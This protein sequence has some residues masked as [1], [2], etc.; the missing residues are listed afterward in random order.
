MTVN[1]CGKAFQAKAPSGR[2]AERGFHSPLQYMRWLAVRAHAFQRWWR[3][4]QK[5]VYH[6]MNCANKLAFV[7]HAAVPA[8]FAPPGSAT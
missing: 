8:A 6:P 7:W 3:Y 4:R 1:S 2:A 5:F